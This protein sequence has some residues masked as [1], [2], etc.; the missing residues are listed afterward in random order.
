METP[1]QRRKRNT[2]SVDRM[3]EVCNYVPTNLGRLILFHYQ[4]PSLPGRYFWGE[5]GSTSKPF[6]GRKETKVLEFIINM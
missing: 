5:I 1:S 3:K 4:T 6:D 2:L